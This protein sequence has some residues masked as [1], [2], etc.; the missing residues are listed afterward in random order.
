[1]QS[2]QS[3]LLLFLS[4]PLRFH[5]VIVSVE[6][7]VLT[8]SS[9]PSPVLLMVSSPPASAYRCFAAAHRPLVSLTEMDFSGE[10]C[11]PV[12]EEDGGGRCSTS[13]SAVNPKSTFNPLDNGSFSGIGGRNT[14]EPEDEDPFLLDLRPL[15]AS[16][17]FL[18]LQALLSLIRS[19]VTSLSLKGFWRCLMRQ[20]AGTVSS[21]S[22]LEG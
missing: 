13:N 12:E 5:Q 2:H 6:S 8:V 4:L 22:F 9:S 18:V 21:F 15:R 20:G 19:W 3:L 10:V 11:I 1:M 7:E 17:F 16:A 14:P